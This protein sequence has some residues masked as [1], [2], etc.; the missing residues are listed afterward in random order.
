MLCYCFPLRLSTTSLAFAS[1]YLE[2]ANSA[3]SRVIFSRT[4]EF[5]IHAAAN[6][7]DGCNCRP[8]RTGWD[9]EDHHCHPTGSDVDLEAYTCARGDAYMNDE[10]TWIP[11]R[12][13]RAGHALAKS[14][15][16]AHKICERCRVNP[17]TCDWRLQQLRRRASRS[18]ITAPPFDGDFEFFVD[19]AEVS[20]EVLEAFHKRNDDPSI[21]SSHDPWT[22]PRFPHYVESNYR[23]KARYCCKSTRSD[24]SLT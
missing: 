4:I 20:R 12:L 11:C 9:L 21:Y 2:S 3:K 8:P 16:H 24:T 5:Y 1:H 19:E 17:R 18:T 15:Y 22:S 7:S 10:G 14:D 23:F 6:M 13:V